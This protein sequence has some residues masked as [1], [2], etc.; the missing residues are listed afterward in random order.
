M[1]Q[2]VGFSPQ[3][4]W[5][6]FCSTPFRLIDSKISSLP[7]RQSARSCWEFTV[8]DLR[9]P[10]WQH[11]LQEAMLE[12][13][14]EKATRKIQHAETLVSLRFLEV[15]NQP[16]YQEERQALTD[17]LSLLRILKRVRTPAASSVSSS[18]ARRAA[19]EGTP[20]HSEPHV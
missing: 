16:N 3:S 4:F 14:H 7:F 17:A 12:L 5:H 13:D 2:A 6:E 9:F 18:L 15:Q 10:L 1:P 8:T 11:P 20:W 19:V